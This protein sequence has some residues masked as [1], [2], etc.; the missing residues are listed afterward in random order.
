[1]RAEIL[2]IGTELLLGH[3]T[4]TNASW[5]AQQLGPLGIDLFYVSTVGDNLERLTARLAQ[6]RERSDLVIMTGGLGPTEDDLTREGIAAVLHETPLVDEQ[7]EAS[8]RAFFA[9]RGILMPERNI[10][11]A[12]T[13]PSVTILANP[14]GTAPGWWA[15]RDDK[16]LVAMPGVPYEMKRMWQNEVMPRLRLRTGESLFTRILRVA[17]MGESSVEER[18]DAVLH[19]ANPTVATYA[20]RDAVDVR[21]TAK[22]PTTDEAQAMV[23]GVEARVRA[24]LGQHIFGIDDETPQS[25]AL[26]MLMAR[27]LTLATMESCTGGLLSSLITDIPGSSNAFRGGLISY[28]T[29]LKEAWGVPAEV[30]AEHGVVSVE[31]AR[32]M[33]SAVRQQTGASVGLSVT[34]VAG[35][36]EQEGKPVGTIHIAV[37]SPE[38]MRDTSQRF[39][40]PRGEIK[41]RAAY[42]ALNLLR[43]HLLREG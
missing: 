27:G 21:I 8:L 26:D 4:D 42:T 22:A 32:A 2:S 1:M 20:K 17:G 40:G 15:E 38:G 37:A 18:L 33:A 36:D 34:G 3:I 10:K 13:L 14:I 9:S 19:N 39:R 41:L 25:V 24:T 29:E 5:L 16:V 30:I 6:A 23:E 12:W 28:A 31:T 7:L 11:Q 35:P 43:L